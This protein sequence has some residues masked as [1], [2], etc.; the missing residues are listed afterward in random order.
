MKKI[1][2]GEKFKEK[3]KLFNQTCFGLVIQDNKFLCIKKNNEISL[4]GSNIEKNET[5][6]ECLKRSFF[7]KTRHQIHEI[8]ELCTID[9][10]WKTKDKTYVHSLSNIFIVQ[11][12][13]EVLIS[14]ENKELVL[15]EFEDIINLLL[16]PYQKEAI[17]QYFIKKDFNI[18]KNT[19][20]KKI[21]ITE[22]TSLINKEKVIIYCHGLGSNKNQYKRF[23]KK[24][25]KNNISMI[26][27][28]LPAHGEDKTEF[29]NFT[30]KESITYIDNVIKYAKAK[31]KYIYLFGSS[32][33]GYVILNYLIEKKEHYKT[34]LM[35]PAFNFYEII[36]KKMQIDKEYFKSNDYLHLYG[37]VNLYKNAYNEF[38][39]ADVAVKKN[40]YSNIV[41]I[42]GK[43]DK[44]VPY[45]DQKEF[46]QK[47]KL[48]FMPIENGS[49]ELYDFDKK[50]TN[51]ILS[52]ISN[53]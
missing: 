35:C 12:A 33:G 1:I 27:F 13:D 43:L 44:T 40:N 16:E 51:I 26:S 42:Q 34:F 48:K 4:I 53:V 52:E 19:I 38:R 21:Y 7:E 18:T 22:V 25:Y 29:K 46:A 10:Y 14:K 47:N 15:I 28:D 24:F 17:K 37:K 50:I 31:Y 9:Y 49:H 39:K 45:E 30:L 3:T 32:Y 41:I 23:Y 36:N 2:I 6:K 8:K 11:I 20:N 5:P